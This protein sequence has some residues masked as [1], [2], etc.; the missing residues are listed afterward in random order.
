MQR[1]IEADALGF[2]ATTQ[3]ALRG[4]LGVESS[5]GCTASPGLPAPAGVLVLAGLGLALLGRRNAR[6]RGWTSNTIRSA[7]YWQQRKPRLAKK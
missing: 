5:N 4:E 6:R 7:L 2:G 1:E 3:V